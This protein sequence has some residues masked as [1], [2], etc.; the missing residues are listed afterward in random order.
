MTRAGARWR[1][2]VSAAFRWRSPRVANS[3]HPLD[4]RRQPRRTLTLREHAAAL[5][6]DDSL[7][8]GVSQAA[9]IGRVASGRSSRPFRG[10]GSP[11]R[12]P[13]PPPLPNFGLGKPRPLTRCLPGSPCEISV[14]FPGHLRDSPREGSTA[15]GLGHERE[16][17]RSGRRTPGLLLPPFLS[18]PG[19]L[20]ISCA[21]PHNQPCARR[22]SIFVGSERRGREVGGPAS[23]AS[24]PAARAIGYSV[25]A[26]RIRLVA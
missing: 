3:F 21:N 1:P 8:V 6:S 11:F 17:R 25:P 2:S 22:L 12:H 18:R 23:L 13:P 9:P 14:W 15:G 5:E 16:A 7:I 19:P 24:R 20:E 26:R 10:G 4:A